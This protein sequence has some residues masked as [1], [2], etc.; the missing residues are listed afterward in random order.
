[1]EAT[2]IMNLNSETADD[3]INSE[4]SLQTGIRYSPPIMEN[5][6]SALQ[7]YLTWRQDKQETINYHLYTGNMQICL[8]RA[9]L[10]LHSVN[11]SL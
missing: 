5:T 6:A 4:K 11:P 3:I 9:A 7:G 2:Y 8:Y 10:F 1:M